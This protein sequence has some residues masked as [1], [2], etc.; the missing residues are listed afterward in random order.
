MLAY[1]T[2]TFFNATLLRC[3]MFLEMLLRCLNKFFTLADVYRACVFLI[4]QQVKCAHDTKAGPVCSTSLP[5]VYSCR[6][7]KPLV[8]SW[9][10]HPPTPH[11]QRSFYM[12]KMLQMHLWPNTKQCMFFCC[13]ADVGQCPLCTNKHALYKAWTSKDWSHNRINA[14]MQL[15]SLIQRFL[16]SNPGS[17]WVCAIRC[18]ACPLTSQRRAH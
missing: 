17:V 7:W 10:P 11:T 18:S 15:L 14:R 1:S 9:P 6:E 2:C 3:W 12:H 5:P 4:I 8:W 16:G 13:L